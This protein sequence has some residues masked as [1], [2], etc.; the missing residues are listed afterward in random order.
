MTHAYRVP[1]VGGGPGT[2]EGWR[3]RV[4]RGRPNWWVILAVSLGL[5][6]LL[7]ATAGSTPRPAP[8]RVGGPAEPAERLSPR[9]GAH[10]S[11]GTGATPSS[12]TTT[13]TTTPTP[14][15]SGSTGPPSS[16]LTVGTPDTVSTPQPAGQGVTTTTLAPATTTTTYQSASVPADRTQTQGYLDPPLQA[17]NQYGFTGTGAMELSVVWSGD[18]YLTM[19]VSC[20]SGNQSV[21][22]TSA[23]DASLPDASGSCLATV[24]EPSS[25]TV[26]LTYTITIGPSG[27]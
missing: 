3:S 17:S 25:E 23:M 18:T 4:A 10:R 13:S 9:T 20:P 11:A 2:S 15:P 1:V 22:G 6:A 12:T 26:S 14:P 24:S 16:R 19:E 8:H 21:G 7:V 5:M 27:G